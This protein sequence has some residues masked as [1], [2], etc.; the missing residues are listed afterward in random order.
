VATIRITYWQEIPLGVTARDEAGERSVPLPAAFQDL[1]DRVAMR[2]GLAETDAY[3][4]GFR[5]GPAEDRPGSAA[6]A[7]AQV[8]AELEAQLDALWLRH[9]GAP[10]RPG[11]G[12]AGAA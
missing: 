4:E 3:L 6:A 9:L 11:P 1:V 8:A 2:A 12:G 5:R 10:R 7:A